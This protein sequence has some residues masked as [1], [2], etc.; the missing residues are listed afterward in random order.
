MLDNA[1]IQNNKIE[2]IRSWYA[3]ENQK[4]IIGA[5][6]PCP[7][8]DA[9]YLSSLKWSLLLNYNKHTNLCECV[10]CITWDRYKEY[11][12]RPTHCNLQHIVILSL[13]VFLFTFYLRYQS[14]IVVFTKYLV[15]INWKY[16]KT[17]KKNSSFD[18][19]IDKAQVT[20]CSSIS[21]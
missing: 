3:K 14:N 6:C 17:R 5:H 8:N 16:A 15:Y 10:C 11:Y 7:Y 19:F 20:C 2:T 1:P 13:F 4:E 18:Q 9:T 12:L 21:G